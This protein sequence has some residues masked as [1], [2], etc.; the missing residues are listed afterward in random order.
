MPSTA[1][2]FAAFAKKHSDLLYLIFRVFTGFLF[3]SHGLQKVGLL[4][5][6]FGV[7][8]FIG[9]IGL[10]ELAG[11]LAILVGLWTRLAALFG[12]ILMI[13]AYATAHAGKAFL[14]LVNKGELALLYFA[15]FA[16]LFVYGSGIWNIE[17]FVFKREQF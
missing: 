16:I 5:G 9:F 11:G 6:T 15:T 4:D 17:K 8:G 10:C 14:P 7:N 13:S 3:L 12:A 1:P 2:L